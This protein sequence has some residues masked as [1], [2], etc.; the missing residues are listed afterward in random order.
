MKYDHSIKYRTS[1][2]KYY[3]GARYYDPRTSIWLSVD[4]LATYDPFE[5]ENFIDGKH[6]GGIYNSFNHGVYTYCYQNPIKL[7]D[8]NG[9]Q[10]EANYQ[11]LGTALNI[12]KATYQAAYN[13]QNYGYVGEST[14][15]VL[16]DGLYKLS[17]AA[18]IVS[19]SVKVATVIGVEGK[20]SF[21][22]IVKG[23]DAGP[24]GYA[25]GNYGIMNDIGFSGN[26]DTEVIY[27]KGNAEAFKG[28]DIEGKSTEY[29]LSVSRGIYNGSVSTSTA[30]SKEAGE[31]K[32][33][34]AG[35]G[36]GLSVKN[37]LPFVFGTQEN[38][39]KGFRTNSYQ[40]ESK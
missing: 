26:V 30:K 13:K 5:K 18:I 16:R 20:V 39:T 35:A 2:G 11:N 21:G 33:Y 1:T 14:W 34:G 4:A 9:K 7:I 23:K 15:N 10:S 40:D 29:N 36:I 31:L 32:G 25:S 27:P 28:S 24:H 6:N 19:V 37:L 22:L 38:T 3:Y 17:P 8:P 12:D